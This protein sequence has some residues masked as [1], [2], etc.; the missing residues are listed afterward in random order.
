MEHVGGASA[1]GNH[2]SFALDSNI[3]FSLRQIIV[4][5]LDS[6]H[7]LVFLPTHV[8]PR[9]LRDGE[10]EGVAGEGGSPIA[11]RGRVD[12]S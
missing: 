10:G 9:P 6:L 12:E 11:S 1:N 7:V 5:F 2:V 3:V 4:R 8:T